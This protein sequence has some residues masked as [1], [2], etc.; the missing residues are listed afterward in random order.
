MQT[1]TKHF[2]Q[3][4]F[5]AIFALVISAANISAA[6]FTVTNT[7]DSGAGSLRRAIM[8]AMAKRTRRFSDLPIRLGLSIAQR[9]ER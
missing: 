6:T 1:I 2:G 3:I 8:T 7:N 4:I 9:Q 5:T